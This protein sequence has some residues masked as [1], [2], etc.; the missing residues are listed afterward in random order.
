M[1]QQHV[2]WERPI[3]T[4]Y[5]NNM[6]NRQ[7]DIDRM[8]W[9]GSVDLRGYYKQPPS[10]NFNVGNQMGSSM[11]S[12]ANRQV[13]NGGVLP[14]KP[15]STSHKLNRFNPI[16]QGKVYSQDNLYQVYK[17]YMKHI[18]LGG[19]QDKSYRRPSDKYMRV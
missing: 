9:N 3:A 16:T 2:N 12:R 1:A 10:Q 5:Y 17:N 14:S 6:L 19:M 11:G 13:T 15:I 4:T 7:K 8:V 18:K